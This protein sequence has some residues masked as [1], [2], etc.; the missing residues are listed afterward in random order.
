MANLLV[1]GDLYQELDGQL[2]EIKR[3]MRQVNGYPFDPSQL[4]SHLQAAIEG[5]F[6][7]VSGT[8]K[9]DMRKEGWMLL[10]NVPCRL[11]SIIEGV[12]FLKGSE[13]SVNGEEMARRARVELDAHY[14]Q[15]DAEWALENQDK[16]PAELRKFYLVFPGTIWQDSRGRRPVPGLNWYGDRWLLSFY[17]LGSVWL[18]RCRLVRPRK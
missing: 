5:R 2:S 15:E 18:S 12:S 6:G 8:F 14:G 17:W 7:L 10:E 1:A 9:R 13:T 11:N 3:Q 4:K 16:I